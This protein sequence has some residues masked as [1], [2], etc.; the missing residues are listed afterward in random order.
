LF[1]FAHTLRPPV[2]IKIRKVKG[3]ET[4]A[5][6][7]KQRD[8]VNRALIHMVVELLFDFAAP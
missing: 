8:S 4:E 3:K 5:G 7:M 1:S 6:N 2:S